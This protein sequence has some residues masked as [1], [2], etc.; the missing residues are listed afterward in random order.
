MKVSK[1]NTKNG[2]W[3]E[4][5][6]E[7]HLMLQVADA[8]DTLRVNV[9]MREDAIEVV[10]DAHRGRLDVRDVVAGDTQARMRVASA[11]APPGVT[12]PQ[13]F[14]RLIGIEWVSRV[15]PDGTFR[16]QCPACARWRD[17]NHETGCWLGA[18]LGS[19]SS[20]NP[21]GHTL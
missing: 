4:L 21:G 19:K 13:L 11:M 9:H 10:V 8:A 6:D 3:E 5:V 16:G 12:L 20:V 14:Q 17:E 15:Q 1:L 7:D 2:S 18:Q